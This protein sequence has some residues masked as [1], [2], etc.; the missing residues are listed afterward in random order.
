[1]V[2]EAAGELGEQSALADAGLADEKGTAETSVG[3]GLVEQG[4]E[5]GKL[6]FPADEL[7]AEAA[8]LGAGARQRR[9]RDP[10]AQ[11]LL[12]ALHRDRVAGVEGEGLLGGG[13]GGLA[14]GDGHRWGHRLQAR[15]HVDGVAGE[16][17]LAARGVDVGAHERL[18]GVDPD[19]D[20]DGSAADARQGVEL[21]DDAQAG[22]HGAL[23]VVLVHGRHAEDGDHGVADELLDRAAVGLDRRAGGGVEALQEGVDDLRVVAFGERREADEVADEG[24]DDATFLGAPRGGRP[25]MTGGRC[26]VGIHHAPPGLACS[27]DFG[28]AVA[29]ARVAQAELAELVEAPG[30]EG[31]VLLEGQGVVGVGG[32][33]DD[34]RP[35]VSAADLCR[36]VSADGVA[37]AELA[38]G[39][40]APGP[41][42]AILLQGHAV[43]AEAADGRPVAGAADPGRAVSL[44]GVAEAQLAEGVAAPGPQRTVLLQG[45]AV[46]DAG[47]DG[48]PVVAAAD[49]GRGSA[50][51]PCLPGRG[52]PRR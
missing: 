24:G 47:R 52:C 6:V 29:V 15:R 1:M 36:S 16:E 31:A 51:S 21:V 22:A 26:R 20:L 18:A 41:Q 19:A 43:V 2:A 11:R 8:Q 30:P 45:Q 40:L 34:R 44:G 33:M 46:A 7:G 27:A 4:L 17:A 48:R 39:V 13:V 10:G 12:L 35:L 14:D 49:P 3:G 9:G 37:Q 42:R 5:L 25:W 38:V 28:R 32:A 50:G 23:G